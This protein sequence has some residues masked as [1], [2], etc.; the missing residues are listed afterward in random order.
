MSNQNRCQQKFPCGSFSVRISRRKRQS[1]NLQ[2]LLEGELSSHIVEMKYVVE[3][4]RTDYNHYRPHSRLGYMTP[5]GFAEQMSPDR[6]YQAA[7]ASA[8]WSPLT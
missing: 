1:R 6:L 3:R 5:A 8:Q 4:W 2:E 7:Y